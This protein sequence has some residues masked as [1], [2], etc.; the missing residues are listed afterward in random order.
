MGANTPSPWTLERVDLVRRRWF[1]RASAMTIAR[2]LNCGIS[3]NAVI[4]VVNRNGFER[5]G[6][7][8]PKLEAPKPETPAP[9]RPP[10][11]R[12]LAPPPPRD[13]PKV[14]S[15]ELDAGVAAAGAGAGP[16]PIW[17]LKQCEC[18]W[19]LGELLD[20]PDLFCGAATSGSAWCPAH[21]R[22]VYAAGARPA[23]VAQ[24]VARPR[25]GAW[26]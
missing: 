22:L 19:P 20:P 3:R 1:E 12:P 9:G 25:S 13:L 23:A 2:E 10:P 17:Q 7:A 11:P 14:R 26:A 21:E 8:P 6:P 15:P 4:G 18:R 24:R 16:R 5:G